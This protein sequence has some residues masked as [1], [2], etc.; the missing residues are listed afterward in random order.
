MAGKAWKRARRQARLSVNV[1][2]SIEAACPRWR[3]LC[4]RIG[5]P[6]P[7]QHWMARYCQRHEQEIRARV[8]KRGSHY[9]MRQV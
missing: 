5:L 1:R 2:A 9:T 8:A 7:A 3:K 6:G 4:V